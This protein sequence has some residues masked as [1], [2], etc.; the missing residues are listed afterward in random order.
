MLACTSPQ[1]ILHTAAALYFAD[2]QQR[3]LQPHTGRHTALCC[4]PFPVAGQGLCCMHAPGWHKPCERRRRQ[5]TPGHALVLTMHVAVPPGH[6]YSTT[7]RTVHRVCSCSACWHTAVGLASTTHTNSQA[8]S[9]SFF[10]LTM[11]EMHQLCAC[12]CCQKQQ[13]AALRCSI[14]TITQYNQTSTAR[15]GHMIC[16]ACDTYTRQHAHTASRHTRLHTQPSS[17]SKP[18]RGYVNGSQTENN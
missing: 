16:S 15:P 11:A 2:Q 8:A 18:G 6:M 5:Q 12:V 9:T 10:T 7:E 13:R 4:S 1:H 3:S 17:C 14:T